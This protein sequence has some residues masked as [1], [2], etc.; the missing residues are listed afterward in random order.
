MFDSFLL[1][2]VEMQRNP[3]DA[4]RQRERRMPRIRGR[5]RVVQRFGEMSARTGIPIVVVHLSIFETE[6][7]PFEA[8]AKQWAEAEGLYY[9]ATREAFRGTDHRDFWIHG[10]NMHPNARA[11]EIFADVVDD[12]L[13]ANHLLGP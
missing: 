5:G 2:L 9:V 6:K 13:R 8:P 3:R 7:N 10:L 11:N 12:F 1:K 4:N